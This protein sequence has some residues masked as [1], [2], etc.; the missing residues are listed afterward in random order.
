MSKKLDCFIKEIKDSLPFNGFEPNIIGKEKN[1]YYFSNKDYGNKL[2]EVFDKRGIKSK[3]FVL[4]KGQTD[5][6]KICS[7][8]SSA[9]LCF[10]YFQDEKNIEFE[11]HLP[12]PTGSGNPAQPDAKLGS[13]YYECKCQEI[14]D[15]EGEMLDVSYVK[16]LNEYFGIEKSKINIFEGKISAHLSD[17]KVDF[18]EDY[19]KTH[20]NVKQLITHLI[21]IANKHSNSNRDEV[22]KLQYIFFTP[23]KSKQ[24]EDTKKTYEELNK[25]IDAIWESDMIAFFKENF[26]HIELCKPKFIS[27]D[28][29][30]FKT[31]PNDLLKQM[32]R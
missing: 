17:L 1:K 31:T 10:L 12:N 15:G 18:E 19:D 9:R 14:V 16:L 29:E 25:E 5:Y 24:S 27:V 22:V 32:E 21:A 26:K 8:S 3:E 23:V 28:N 30:C 2:K 6:Y 7:V 13:I 20:F 11:C 4:V